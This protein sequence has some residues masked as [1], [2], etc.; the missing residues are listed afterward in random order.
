MIY[1]SFLVGY[2]IGIVSGVVVYSHG[3]WWDVAFTAAGGVGIYA[4]LLW[5]FAHRR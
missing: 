4:L 2:V 3:S 5:A 1:P